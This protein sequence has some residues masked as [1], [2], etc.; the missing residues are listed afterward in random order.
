MPCNAARITFLGERY[1]RIARRRGKAK[2]QVAVA[3]SIL[4]IIWH[5]LT[6]PAAR[7]TDLGP[8][9]YQAP[10]IPT[11]SS[12]TPGRSKRSASPSPSPKPDTHTAL[13]QARSPHQARARCRAPISAG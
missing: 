3:R 8:G 13:D 4:V 7:F 11:A 9:Y 12:A 5:L 10:P 1:G 2:A 6:D